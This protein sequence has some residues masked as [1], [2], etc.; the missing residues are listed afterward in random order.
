MSLFCSRVLPLSV[1]H[2][3]LVYEAVCLMLI[4]NLIQINVSFLNKAMLSLKLNKSKTVNIVRKP[5]QP[6]YL[7]ISMCE[8]NEMAK[9]SAVNVS[10]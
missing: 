5:V 2:V 4:K 6:M 7:C 3:L 1:G 9:G 8:I 10:S